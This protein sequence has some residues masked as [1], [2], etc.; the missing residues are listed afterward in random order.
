MHPLGYIP[1]LSQRMSDDMTKKTRRFLRRAAASAALTTGLLAARIGAADENLFGY[2]KG[3]ETIPQGS[4][5]VYEWLTSRSG[6]G[7]GHYTALNSQTE[8]E[9]G[10]TNRFS[11]SG[12]VKLQSID[13]SGLVID[14]YLPQDE[15]YGLRFSGIEGSV[16][17]NFLSPALDDF[18]LSTYVS[19]VYDRLDPHSGQ[20]KA[21][22]SV[23]GTLLAQKY[24]FEGQLV[25]VANVGTEAT[26]ATRGPIENLP[27]GFD[28]PINP[29]IEW[30]WTVG[31]GATYRFA[32]NW[33][34][35]LELVYQ[36]EFET[37]VGQER[38]SL[39]AGP[40]LHYGA[41]RWWATLT[42]T[43]QLRGGGEQYPRQTETDLHLVE[44]TERE[45][46]FKFGFNF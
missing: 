10:V 14:G 15:S 28:W 42:W 39:F 3:A 18:G 40:S 27:P 31:S 46:R 43:P 38:W 20:D 32:R 37:E 26:R 1:S 17:Y 7:A 16:K 19:L 36:T 23:E 25:W 45:V 5:E 34:A 29:E 6:K 13:T 41:Q 2:V 8:I 30:E 24:F 35:G 4:W 22:Y 21:A 11:V 44:K 12:N 9:Y 33:Y